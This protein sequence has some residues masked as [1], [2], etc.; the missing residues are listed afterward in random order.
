MK[1]AA[2]LLMMANAA[3]FFFGAFNMQASP[4]AL[5]TN[6]ASLRLRLW[7][8]CV[9]CLCCGARPRSFAMGECDGALQ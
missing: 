8:R 1:A 7:K 2:G 4:S 3:L 6:R 9:G 5:S